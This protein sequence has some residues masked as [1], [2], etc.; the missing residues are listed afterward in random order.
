MIYETKHTN[1]A[2]D[3][4][5]RKL[6]FYAGCGAPRDSLGEAGPQERDRNQGVANVRD[7][8]LHPPQRQRH[9]GLD[10]ISPRRLRSPLLECFQRGAAEHR[11]SN[12]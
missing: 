5:P 7:S 9:G 12:R 4:F 6:I 11:V 10:Q 8:S 1:Q 2:I 3:K